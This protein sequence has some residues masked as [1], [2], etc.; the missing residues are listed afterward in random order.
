[1]SKPEPNA[2]PRAEA[3]RA[4]LIRAAL[5]L[6]GAK[7]FE[8]TSTREIAASARA[9][10]AAI[11]YHFGG[12]EGL[13]TA[14]ADFVA[15][16]IGKVFAD[17]EG[18]ANEIEKLTP[19][20]ARDALARIVEGLIDAIVVKGDAR[21]IVRFVL[22]EMFEPSAAFERVYL[23]IGPMHARACAMWSR[24]TGAGPESEMTLLTIFSLVGQVIYFRLARPAVLRRMEWSEIGAKESSAIKRLIVR[25]LDAALDLARKTAP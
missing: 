14:C 8:A 5:D 11:A 20:E 23:A 18:A 19:S 9:N 15:A 10:V 2:S 4:A 22:R 21:P 1:M 6:F 3:T 13:R 12:K 7:G 16:T 24:A 25:N 17:A